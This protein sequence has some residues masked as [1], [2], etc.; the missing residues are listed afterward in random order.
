MDKKYCN[1][2]YCED[3][4]EYDDPSI[5]LY[6]D[7]AVRADEKLLKKKEIRKKERKILH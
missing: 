2:E 5:D 6:Y 1:I 3:A 4:D 7:N